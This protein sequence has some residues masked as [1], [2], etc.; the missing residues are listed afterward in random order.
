MVLCAPAMPLH[1]LSR[2]LANCLG[3]VPACASLFLIAS[4]Q[5]ALHSTCS[6]PNGLLPALASW[7]TGFDLP[8]PLRFLPLRMHA[9]LA[10]QA[11]P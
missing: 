1:L 7:P 10:S 2:M 6:E 8:D 4:M 3:L 11:L 5:I 9:N